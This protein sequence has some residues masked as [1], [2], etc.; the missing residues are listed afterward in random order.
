MGISR[1]VSIVLLFILI[2]VGGSYCKRRNFDPSEKRVMELEERNM[3]RRR[4]ACFRIRNKKCVCE[5]KSNCY[6]SAFSV[7]CDDLTEKFTIY[8]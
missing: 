4:W 6:S 8:D 7:D 2:G 5:C 3:I 1:V